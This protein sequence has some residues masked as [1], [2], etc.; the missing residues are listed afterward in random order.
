MHLASSQHTLPKSGL[1][2]GASCVVSPVITS[3]P[4]RLPLRPSP[5]NL[6]IRFRCSAIRPGVDGNRAGLRFYLLTSYSACHHSYPGSLAG[7]R[8][9]YFPASSGVRPSRKGSA[10]SLTVVRIIPAIRLSQ[11]ISTG[12]MHYGAAVFA[13]CYGLLIWRAPRA[14]YHCVS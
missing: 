13:S 4:V 8:S 3:G 14:G 2:L 1:T 11:Q 7:A 12:F 10:C 9:L 5:S 6:Y